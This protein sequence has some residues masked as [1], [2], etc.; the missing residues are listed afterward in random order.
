[1]DEVTKE[2]MRDRLGNV[3]QI[4]TL[5]FGTQQKEYEGRFKKLESEL[6][7]LQQEMRDRLTQ[8]HE[9]FSTELRAAVATLEQKIQYLSSTSQDKFSDVRQQIDRTEANFSEQ[10]TTLTETVET[11][12]ESLANEIADSRRKIKEEI[13]T[14][15]TQI[16]EDMNKRFSGLKDSKVSREDLAEILFELCM[17][18]K[19]TDFAELNEAGEYKIKAD[20]M[21]PER[22]NG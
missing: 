1:M 20:L 5:L 12:R 7:N 6:S 2:E 22:Q 8:L 9:M 11:Q 21:L 16:F 13:Q 10:L 14:L 3:D 18:V 19:G 15:K 17:R 4:R